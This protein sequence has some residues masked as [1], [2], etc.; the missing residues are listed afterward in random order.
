MVERKTGRLNGI[1][2]L[3][4]CLPTLNRENGRRKVFEKWLFFETQ[5]ALI[6]ELEEK[7][8]RQS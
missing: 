3:L 5:K 7:N 6:F 8:N 1:A 2:L 4:L